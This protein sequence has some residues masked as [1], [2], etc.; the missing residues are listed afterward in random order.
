M[1]KIAFTLATLLASSL[2]VAAPSP[3]SSAISLPG[4]GKVSPA[5]VLSVSLAPLLKEVHYDLSCQISNSQAEAVDMR[6]E[7]SHSYTQ[8]G[9]VSLNEGILD[10]LQ[11]SLQVGENTLTVA[12][13]S[14][15]GNGN[16]ALQ[17][18]NL[19]FNHTVEVSNCLAKPAIKPRLKPMSGGSFIA[20]NDTGYVVNMKVGNFFPTPY[21]IYPYS[22][23]WIFVST[24][25]QNISISDIY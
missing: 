18:K 1:K 9:Q 12:E 5:G 6:F 16:P 8:Y 3:T 11:G 7:L 25:N 2:T 15:S 23:R 21:T 10:N 13:I 19:D 17:F 4:G 22:S 14:I 24:D 20:Y